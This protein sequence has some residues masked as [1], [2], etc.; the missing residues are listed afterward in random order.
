MMSPKRKH[1]AQIPCRNCDTQMIDGRQGEIKKRPGL[2]VM[3]SFMNHL[4]N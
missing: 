3:M 1:K 2:A 4:C